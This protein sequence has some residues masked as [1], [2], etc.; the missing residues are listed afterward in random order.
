MRDSNR[1]TAIA[2]SKATK[3]GLYHDGHGLYLKVARSRAKSWIFRFMQTR[4]A[5]KMGLGPTHTITLAEARELALQARKLL[6]AGVDPIEARI[7]TRKAARIKSQLDAAKAL[8]FNQSAEAYISAHRASWR[9]PKH[10]AQWPAT[11]ATYAEPIIGALPVQAIDTALVMKVLEQDVAGVLGRPAAALWTA[12]PET[13][14]R[15][16]GRIESILDWA[17]ARGYREGANPAR[18]RGHLDQL[19]PRRSAV[20]RRRHQPALPYAQI[21]AFMAELR[22]REGVSPLALELVILTAA[23]TDEIIGAPR[24]EFDLH[25]KIWTVP[26][27]RMKGKR[28][29]RVPLSDAAISIIERAPVDGVY[30]FPGAR[31][32]EPLSDMALLQLIKRMNAD[33]TAAA[34]PRWIDPKQGGADIVTHGFR[35][36]F[37]DWGSEITAYP[38]EMLEIALAHAVSDKTEAAYRRLDMMERRRRL[39]SDWADYCASTPA[40]AAARNNVVPMRHGEGQ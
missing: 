22:A 21:P 38:N 26:A 9:N 11:I 4:R 5:R 16:R 14:S 37:R 32:G 39:M 10:A 23:R 20:R 25:T 24:T 27:D 15:L 13:A 31:A 18:W 34:R 7:E 1:L 28:E 2:V 33:A 19:L 17:T 40:Q 12:R 36:T 30:L 35:S 8:T 29:H 3:P 6:Q